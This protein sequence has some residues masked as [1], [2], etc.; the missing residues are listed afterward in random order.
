L[1]LY[2]EEMVTADPALPGKDLPIEARRNAREKLNNDL[3]AN[4]LS[5]GQ[6]GRI[7][8]VISLGNLKNAVSELVKRNAE[9]NLKALELGWNLDLK[10]P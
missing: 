8:G 7:L 3:A 10:L 5:I 2:D 1:T 9:I 4:I 6:I